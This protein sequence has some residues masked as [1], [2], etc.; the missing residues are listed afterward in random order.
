MSLSPAFATPSGPLR[1]ADH[2]R[3]LQAWQ[4]RAIAVSQ[5]CR[6]LLRISVQLPPHAD[7]AP[8]LRANTAV[9]IQLGPAFGNVS[10]IYTVHG[11]DAGARQFQLDVVLHPSPGPM[12]AWVRALEPGD[13]FA[14]TGPRPHLQVPRRDGC[15]ALL[16]ADPSAIPALSTLLRQWPAGLRAQAWLA[17]DDPFPVDELPVVE[18]IGLHRLANEGTPLLQ[19]A[20]ALPA[21]PDCVIWAAG[22]REEMRALRRHFTEVIGLDRADVAVAGYWKRG[23]TT[24]ETDQRRRR[25]YARVLARG[26][27]LQD[28]DDLADD[29]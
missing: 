5:P 2:D 16:F 11:V 7:M 20:R 13:A 28:V 12:L 19:R 23:E 27:G 15:T 25:S 3:G 10:R 8:W 18:G 4:V 29:I 17:S 24:T 22:E 14:L 9:R 26:G 1:G 21:D 6:S